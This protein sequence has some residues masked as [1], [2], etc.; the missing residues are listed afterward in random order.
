[1]NMRYWLGFF[2][3]VGVGAMAVVVIFQMAG[4]LP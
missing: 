4:M 1:M 2:S 3:G